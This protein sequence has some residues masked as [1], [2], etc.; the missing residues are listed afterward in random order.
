MGPYWFQMVEGRQLLRAFW[1]SLGFGFGFR[2]SSASPGKRG[3]PLSYIGS[4]GQD[5]AITG[6]KNGSQFRPTLLE[7][8]M[9]QN[10][11]TTLLAGQSQGKTSGL[12]RGT[13]PDTHRDFLPWK[14]RLRLVVCKEYIYPPA[15]MEATGGC[16][17]VSITLTLDFLRQI[18]TKKSSDNSRKKTCVRPLGGS[19]WQRCDCAASGLGSADNAGLAES[20]FKTGRV[21]PECESRGR[22]LNLSEALSRCSTK[23]LYHKGHSE[24]YEC[25]RVKY[26]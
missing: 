22:L 10:P 19:I 26:I 17:Y 11:E 20:G 18:A 4:V 7:N 12:G 6:L 15:Q 21:A 24:K 9:V 3:R 5:R 2:G 25:H 23:E 14:G 1:R 13:W 16:L 8:G